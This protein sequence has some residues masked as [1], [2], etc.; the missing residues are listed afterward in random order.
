M[1]I[2]EPDI[3]SRYRMYLLYSCN[4]Q[5]VGFP[6]HPIAFDFSVVLELRR[7]DASEMHTGSES[8]ESMFS[9]RAIC[10]SV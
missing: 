5:T 2:K 6:E 3:E 9:I 4:L 7:Q 8:Y 10:S 1:Q